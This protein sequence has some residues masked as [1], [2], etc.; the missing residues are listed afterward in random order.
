MGKKWPK[1]LLAGIL[2]L[3]VLNLSG[4]QSRPWKDNRD[5]S[6]EKGRTATKTLSEI[7][8]L[9]KK[10]IDIY[11]EYAISSNGEDVLEGKLWISGQNLCT[12]SA[13]G[14]GTSV[15]IHNDSK[16]YSYIYTKGQKQAIRA[17]DAQPVADINPQQCL[18][19]VEANI[20]ILGK[21]VYDGKDCVVIQYK[22]DEVETRMWIWEEQG[23]PVRIER[24]Y[25]NEITVMKYHNYKFA[26]LPHTLFELPPGMDVVE[27]PGMDMGLP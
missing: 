10:T 15:F 11:C 7:M 18:L 9:G 4:C 5:D 24:T 1:M 2:A 3:L 8:D 17:N 20:P 13:Q 14:N 19:K 12:E 21:Q 16:G 22:G 27:F 6:S 26:R 23:L 25:N